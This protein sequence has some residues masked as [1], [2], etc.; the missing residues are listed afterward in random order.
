MEVKTNIKINRKIVNRNRNNEQIKE[1]IRY[2]QSLNQR[3][4]QDARKMANVR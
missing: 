4:K 2:C 1:V 3:M